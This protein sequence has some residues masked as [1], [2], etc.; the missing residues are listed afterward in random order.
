M[1]LGLKRLPWPDGSSRQDD[2]SKKVGRVLLKIPR[3]I[4]AAQ[5]TNTHLAYDEDR[6]MNANYS[7]IAGA[8]LLSFVTV[9]ALIWYL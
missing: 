8:F 6:D 5:R 2:F 7:H 4:S 9:L 3:T 1:A